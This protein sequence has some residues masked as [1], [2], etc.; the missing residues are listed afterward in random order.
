MAQTTITEALADLHVITKRVEKKQAFV[1]SYLIRQ[2]KLKDPLATA[3]NPGGSV[4]A[5]QAETQAINDLLTRIIA[6]RRAITAANLNKMLTIGERTMSVFD[7]LVWR[8]E[9]APKEQEFLAQLH[10]KIDGTRLQV[11][12][13]GVK[14]VGGNVEGVTPE[15]FRV[16]LDEQV[17]ATRRESLEETLG[18]LDGLLSL[19][20]ATTLIDVP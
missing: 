3:Q 12:R 17:L 20:N 19:V 11:Q 18:K 10:Q 4:A 7:W 6:I 5:I 14:I 13:Q 2:E 16:S 8:R 1:M 15:D 9:V